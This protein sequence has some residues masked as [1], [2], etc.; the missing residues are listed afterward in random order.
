MDLA[1]FGDQ[2]AAV[3]SRVS[4]PC[5]SYLH[6]SQFTLTHSLV[7]LRNTL[8]ARVVPGRSLLILLP[9]GLVD[10]YLVEWMAMFL[11]SKIRLALGDAC[12]G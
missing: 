11:L 10:M 8:L 6:S 2:H 4:Y 1:G 5:L 9:R 3:Y 12:T 7:S